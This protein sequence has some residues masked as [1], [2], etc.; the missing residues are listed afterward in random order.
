M[1]WIPLQDICDQNAGLLR[2][3]HSTDTASL[4]GSLVGALDRGEQMCGAYPAFRSGMDL[5]KGNPS[6]LKRF[7]AFAADLAELVQILAARTAP[8]GLHA[9]T[10]G[11]RFIAGIKVPMGDLL[12]QMLRG[13]GIEP[14]HTA[15]RRILAKKMAHRNSL[16][17]TMT[18]ERIIMGS[19]V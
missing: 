3:T 13:S 1:M 18:S 11:D 4:G 19:K 14:L 12:L 6:G 16:S 15:S 10:I 17:A 8:G 7:S 2:N 9:W 5:L